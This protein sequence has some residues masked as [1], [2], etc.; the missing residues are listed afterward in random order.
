[1]AVKITIEPSDTGGKEKEPVVIELNAR[2]AL[3][4]SIMIMDHEDIDIVIMPTKKK[5][6]ALAKELLDDKVYGA[7]DRLF[8]FLSKRGVIENSSVVKYPETCNFLRYLILLLF[9]ILEIMP[10]LFFFSYC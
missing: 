4:G 7:Q 2:R 10:A 5:C 6:L 3:D 8:R 9:R 1:M